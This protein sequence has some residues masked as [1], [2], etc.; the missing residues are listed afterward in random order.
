V[1]HASGDAPATGPDAPAQ[2]GSADSAPPGAP[3]AGTEGAPP[4]DAADGT[5][6]TDG[7]LVDGA[8]DTAPDADTVNDSTAPRDAG[9]SSACVHGTC[10]ISGG[11]NCDTGWVGPLCDMSSPALVPGVPVAG[12]V[13]RGQWAYFN[14][15]GLASGLSAT[16]TEDTT[17]GLVWAYLRAGQTP[18]QSSNLAADENTQS[19]S[20]PVTHTFASPGTQTWYVGAYGQPAIPSAT[21]AVAFHVQITVIP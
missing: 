16:V 8:A 14:Y 5:L 1:D 17:V 15:V 6:A 13:V 3:E 4:D 9:C 12:S 2:E 19:A 7:T 18:T 20:H 11:C 21:Q 10:L